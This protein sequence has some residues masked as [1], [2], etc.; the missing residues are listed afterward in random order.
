MLSGA[1]LIFIGNPLTDLKDRTASTNETLKKGS[2][3]LL[4]TQLQQKLNELGENIGV[5][6]QFGSETQT[7]L[8]SVTGKSTITEKQ[9]KKL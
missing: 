2:T 6:G 5:D 1:Y 7:A 9:I 3:G 4:V 8:L